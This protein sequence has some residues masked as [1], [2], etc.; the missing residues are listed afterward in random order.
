MGRFGGPARPGPFYSEKFRPVGPNDFFRGFEMMFFLH[1]YRIGKR[2]I[3]NSLAP[4]ALL[5]EIRHFE[6]SK[7]DFWGEIRGHI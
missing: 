6:I 5:A 3:S 7:D 1:E 2:T 4:K